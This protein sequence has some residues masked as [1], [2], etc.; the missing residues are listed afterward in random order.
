MANR[1]HPYSGTDHREPEDQEDPDSGH[2]F[3]DGCLADWTARGS[4]TCPLCRTPYKKYGTFEQ[5]LATF[6][7]WKNFF[8]AE[9]EC[10]AANGVSEID[11]VRDAIAFAGIH[12]D[13]LAV[14]TYFDAFQNAQIL[15]PAPL[16]ADAHLG[17]RLHVGQG[18]AVEDG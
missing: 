18:A 11:V 12:R 13:E 15:A 5:R 14:L 6:K 4:L 2:E 16:A 7:K 17:K 9:P 8:Q 1:D 10:L 3:C